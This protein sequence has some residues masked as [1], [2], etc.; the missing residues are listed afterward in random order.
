MSNIFDEQKESSSD[1]D[2]CWIKVTVT[3]KEVQ[4]SI[5]KE[6]SQWV[7]RLNYEA[8][9]EGECLCGE[10][11][12]CK[13]VKAADDG[14][15]N[16]PPDS[17]MIW[18]GSESQ[19]RPRCRDIPHSPHDDSRAITGALTGG[20]TF[21]TCMR[22]DDPCETQIDEEGNLHYW[23]CEGGFK[24]KIKKELIAAL[25]AGTNPGSSFCGNSGASPAFMSGEIQRELEARVKHEAETSGLFS[26][27]NEDEEEPPKRFSPFLGGYIL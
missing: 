2:Q 5:K 12:A 23:V 14:V 6:D 25:P 16:P 21:V 7:L 20:F 19:N 17:S 13:E 4:G 15:V 8:D 11:E 27:N 1:D 22:T 18:K 3:S 26:C 9:V 24:R 10:E